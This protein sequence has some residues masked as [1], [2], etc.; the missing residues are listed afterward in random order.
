MDGTLESRKY[1]SERETAQVGRKQKWLPPAGSF[2]LLLVC[3]YHLFH[4]RRAPL[5]APA[6]T[7]RRVFH[8]KLPDPVQLVDPQRVTRN[9]TVPK[10]FHFG[11]KKGEKGGLESSSVGVM[12]PAHECQS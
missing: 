4:V 10:V 5:L 9:G 11:G 6:S 2:Q 3:P 7:N 12:E 8:F 1:K